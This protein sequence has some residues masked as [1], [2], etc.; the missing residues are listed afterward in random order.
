M[1]VWGLADGKQSL[2][3]LYQLR[4]TLPYAGG[5]KIKLSKETPRN[6]WPLLYEDS[7]T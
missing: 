2:N 5:M 6:V 1:F 3:H 4:P 7:F